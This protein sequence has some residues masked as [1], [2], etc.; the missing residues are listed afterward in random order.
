VY[1]AREYLSPP[2]AKDESTEDHA[3]DKA[4]AAKN[5]VHRHGNIIGKC[6][7]IEQ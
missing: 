1:N 3:H 2:L 6:D 7:V 4:S 5:D